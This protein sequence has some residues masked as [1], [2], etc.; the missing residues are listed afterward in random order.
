MSLPP[1]VWKIHNCLTSLYCY[2]GD[3][4]K[5]GEQFEN[6]PPDKLQE[7]G[8]PGNRKPFLLYALKHFT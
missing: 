5:R 4:I 8:V 2:Q 3:K 7:V 6:I 1:L